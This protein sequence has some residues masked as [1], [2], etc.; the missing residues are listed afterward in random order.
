MMRNPATVEARIWDLL[1][2]K[3]QRI[4][5][6]LTNAM[7]EREDITRLVIGIA[8]ESLF[9]ELYS[10]AQGKSGESLSNWFDQKTATLGGR[11]VIDTARDLF[12]N[13]ARFD[14]QSVGRDV[15]KV[16]LPALEPFFTALL[17]WHSRRVARTDDGGLEFKTPESWRTKS[18][19]VEDRY[20]GLVFDRALKGENAAARVLGV[21]HQLMNLALEEAHNFDARLA[22]ISGL[23]TPLLVVA[24]EDEVTG[25]GSTTR[26]L[27]FGVMEIG[28][29]LV[30]LHDWELV[31]FLNTLCARKPASA[32]KK[33]NVVNCAAECSA[34]L[35]AGIRANMPRTASI[36]V[37]PAAR[38]EMLLLPGGLAE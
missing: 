20:E 15:P 2:A 8:G 11:D 10:G 22:A 26:R 38:A 36:F 3:L 9:N 24:V 16:D 23:E 31:E 14:F 34:K 29:D 30:V 35:L 7:E 33:G 6:A 18:W 25:T 19:S 28:D 4:Q 17:Q 13:V 12:G 27:H 1:T 37:R 5:A 21:G 32:G